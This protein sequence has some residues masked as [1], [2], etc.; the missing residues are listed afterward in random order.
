MAEFTGRQIEAQRLVHFARKMLALNSPQALTALTRAV[1]IMLNELDDEG[2]AAGVA[3]VM[4][5][6]QNRE[7]GR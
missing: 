2:R 4:A 7:F 5:V 1:A 3:M 6:L